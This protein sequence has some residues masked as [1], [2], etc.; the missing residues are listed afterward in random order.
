MCP[1]GCSSF[2]VE[3]LL[4]YSFCSLSGHGYLISQFL[5]P[6]TNRR[7]DNYGGSLENRSRII[8]EILSEIKR[9]VPDPTFS[10]SIKLN[11]ADFAVDGF[12]AEDCHA[13]VLMLEKAGL[14]WI[15]LSGGTYEDVGFEVSDYFPSSSDLLCALILITQTGV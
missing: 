11:S 2:Y 15:E 10:L 6:R 13:L 9:R 1:I 3:R 8:F 5:S 12:D 4:L 7:T 14:D